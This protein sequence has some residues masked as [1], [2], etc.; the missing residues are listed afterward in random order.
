MFPLALIRKG[1]SGYSRYFPEI[2]TTRAYDCTFNPLTKLLL[3][4]KVEEL[5][6]KAQHFENSPYLD[7]ASVT[8]LLSSDIRVFPKAL[9]FTTSRKTLRNLMAADSRYTY[10][11]FYNI[12]GTFMRFC[13]NGTYIHMETKIVSGKRNI[14]KF[15]ASDWDTRKPNADYRKGIVGMS[16]T[17]T[18]QEFTEVMDESTFY[19]NC[20]VKILS[21]SISAQYAATFSQKSYFD[22]S[23]VFFG[24]PEPDR[25]LGS[26]KQIP[27]NC[28]CLNIGINCICFVIDNPKGIVVVPRELV[29]EIPMETVDLKSVSMSLLRLGRSVNAQLAE[30]KRYVVRYVPRE[31]IT[32]VV[33]LETCSTR[34]DGSVRYIMYGGGFH[35]CELNNEG[36][37]VGI[38]NDMTTTSQSSPFVSP[39]F[40]PLVEVL[41]QTENVQICAFLE[42]VF[43]SF[44]KA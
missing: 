20:S 22:N 23:K 11:C 40:A 15:L 34:T 17:C 18:P 13:S 32:S 39:S 19:P 28:I 27:F 35:V 24:I 4:T 5:T 26:S 42:R 7:D 21:Y 3:I 14:T 10:E 6:G 44:K 8:E 43:A 2:D 16:M 1:P 12:R 37:I 29:R 9:L 30:A 36:Q 38:R 41:M 33:N 31:E 25:I